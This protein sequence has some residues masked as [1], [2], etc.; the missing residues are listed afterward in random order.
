[1]KD[2]LDLGTQDLEMPRMEEEVRRA[3]LTRRGL[4]RDPVHP[5]HVSHHSL[6]LER[7]QRTEQQ[8]RVRRWIKERLGFRRS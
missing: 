6:G 5:P 3:R 4:R 2:A 8:I 7:T 1:M